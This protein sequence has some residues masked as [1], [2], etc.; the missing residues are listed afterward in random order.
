MTD[1]IQQYLSRKLIYVKMGHRVELIR[2]MLMC[3]GTLYFII[4]YFILKNSGPE[5]EVSLMV[6]WG[7]NL[8]ILL[9]LA[10]L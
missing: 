2:W 4:L 6:I 10:S 8:M 1:R 9:C 7:D 3:R 5:S